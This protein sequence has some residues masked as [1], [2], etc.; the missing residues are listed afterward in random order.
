MPLQPVGVGRLSLYSGRLVLYS[1][2][3]FLACFFIACL[4]MIIAVEENTIVLK[5]GIEVV[6]VVKF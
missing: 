6:G 2:A 3:G 5:V 1:R 4:K